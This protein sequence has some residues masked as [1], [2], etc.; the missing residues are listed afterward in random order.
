MSMETFNHWHS[1]QIIFNALTNFFG[2]SVE[3]I[4]IQQIG[5]STLDD[6]SRKKHDIEKYG[7]IRSDEDR[8]IDFL[9]I[10]RGVDRSM[11]E[12]WAFSDDSQEL[13]NSYGFDVQVEVV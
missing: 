11:A 12:K 10:V 5:S 13:E 7:R 8:D 6:A 2:P 4:S 9:A 1:K 3:V